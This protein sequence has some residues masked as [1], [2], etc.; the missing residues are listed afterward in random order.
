MWTGSREKD[1]K[2]INLKKKKEKIQSISE[3]DW[4]EVGEE[5]KGEIQ[6]RENLSEWE[7][8]PA[9]GA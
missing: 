8:E 9:H 7:L 2:I 1:L 5:Q 3:S 6:N 4:L